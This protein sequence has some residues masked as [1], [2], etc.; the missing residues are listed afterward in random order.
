MGI[1]FRVGRRGRPRGWVLV[2]GAPGVVVVFFVP[3]L[4]ILNRLV[5]RLAPIADEIVLIRAPFGEPA[6]RAKFAVL[7]I[8]DDEQG[9]TGI[10]DLVLVLFALDDIGQGGLLL[11]G[12]WG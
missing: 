2:V 11:L 10:Y 9:V 1:S 5:E 6:D 12:W 4:A 8:A 7:R 3:V